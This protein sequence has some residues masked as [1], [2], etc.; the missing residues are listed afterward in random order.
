MQS[1][2]DA[3]VGLENRFALERCAGIAKSSG[4]KYG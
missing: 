3:Y 2:V 1:I 4:T